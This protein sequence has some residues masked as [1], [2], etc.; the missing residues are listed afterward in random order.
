MKRVYTLLLVVALIFNLTACSK[1][2]V[3]GSIVSQSNDTMAQLDI[4]PQKLF[5]F[6]DIM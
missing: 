2:L 3:K 5:E 1:N 4:M 6:A